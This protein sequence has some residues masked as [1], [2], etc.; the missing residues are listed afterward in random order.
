MDKNETLFYT[1][2][3]FS[4]LIFSFF[5]VL[6]LELMNSSRIIKSYGLKKDEFISISL[7]MSLPQQKSSPKIEQNAKTVKK[8]QV[9]PVVSEEINIDNLFSNVWTKQIKKEKPPVKEIDNKR[10][11]E[12]SKKISTSQQN[13]SESISQK[14]ESIQSLNQS[15]STSSAA[16]VNE[17]LAKI[18]A[19]VYEHFYPPQNSQ[20]HSVKAI[21]E[22]NALGKVLDFRILNYSGNNQLN[23]E[24]DR[25]KERLRTTVFPLNPDNKSGQYIIILTSKE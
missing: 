3:F 17:Y 24:C 1:S 14:I 11:E 18:Q 19:I 13:S 15:E 6:F 8:E 9:D 25:V 16:V 4:L 5:I 7:E 12:I 22:L 21:I 2:G 23:E 10:L 20:G